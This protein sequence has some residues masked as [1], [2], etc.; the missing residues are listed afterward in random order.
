VAREP[1]PDPRRISTPLVLA[2]ASAMVSVGVVAFL[3]SSGREDVPPRPTRPAA[4]P[5]RVDRSTPVS[6]AESFL[7]AWRKRDHEA[8]EALSTGEARAEVVARRTREEAS[9]SD[10]QTLKM[11]IWDSLAR[12]RLVYTVDEEIERSP[13]ERTL[14]GVARGNFMNT[15]YARQ[16][17]FDVV[18]EGDEWTVR[19]M[20][21]GR[22]LSDTPDFLKLAGESGR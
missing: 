19:A 8:A 2:L 5:A 22:V 21:L 18:R 12:D 15:E 9:S 17:E 6:A 14:R 1:T 11:R 10:E 20:R 7:D 16:I 4:A 3:A 13:T